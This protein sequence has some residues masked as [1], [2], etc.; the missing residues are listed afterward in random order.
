MTDGPG[1]MQALAAGAQ[2]RATILVVDDE[3]L[4]RNV[5]RVTLERSGYKVLL[6]RDG[7]E[8]IGVFAANQAQVSLIVLDMHMP[9]VNGVE[10]LRRLRGLDAKAPVLVTSGWSETEVTHRFHGLEIAGILEKPFTARA[11]VERVRE[12]CR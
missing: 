5:A 4:V 6:A 1:A 10:V 7:D 8:A 12:L 3:E 11:L 2:A 9:R